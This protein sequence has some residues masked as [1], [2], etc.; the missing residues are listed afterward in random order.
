MRFRTAIALATLAAALPGC[1]KESAP[2]PSGDDAAT[3]LAAEWLD[4]SPAASPASDR[5]RIAGEPLRVELRV[6]GGA[7]PY[8]IELRAPPTGPA[9]AITASMVAAPEED[10][11]AAVVVAGE[12]AL[13][14][15]APSG[16]LRIRATITDADERTTA[17][18]SAPQEILGA[19]AAERPAPDAPPFAQALDAGG[20]RR[21]RFVRG[22]ILAI[23]AR[24]AA[25]QERATVRLR[26]AGGDELARW[27][28]HPLDRGALR[29]P[30]QVPPLALP[31]DYLVELES[32]GVT[33]RLPLTIEGAPFPPLASLRIDELVLTAGEDGRS[34]R[35]GR[36]GRGETVRVRARVGAVRRE[37]SGV[38]RLRGRDGAVVLERTL[39]TARPIAVHPSARV[40][41]VGAAPIEPELPPGRYMI[42]VEVSEDDGVSTIH[43][44]VRLR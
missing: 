25:D 8:R 31:G 12:V 19:G 5:P 38:L 44:E 13:A 42:E 17:V 21:A 9:A 40:Y 28:D 7:P 35:A 4:V 1:R 23:E 6:T 16:P 41:L 37:V 11:A 22:E 29:F 27:E 39:G 15:A 24:F 30:L 2:A 18:D 32:S 3:T 14:A 43:R 20:R 33:A 10:D 26:A 34:P 36:L